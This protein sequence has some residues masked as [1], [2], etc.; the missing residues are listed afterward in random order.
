MS[1]GKLCSSS[2]DLVV[3]A[4]SSLAAMY[5]VGGHT[6][7]SPSPNLIDELIDS[8]PEDVPMGYQFSR[9]S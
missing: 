7:R 4:L 6:I 8:V 9:H 5:T 1:G 3:E 2:I